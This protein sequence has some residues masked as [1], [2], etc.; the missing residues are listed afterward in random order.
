VPLDA[1]AILGSVAKTGRLVIVDLANKTCGAAAEIAAIAA[2]EVF[3]ALAAPIVRVTT[4]DV[5]IPFSP[6]LEMPLYPDK[7]KIVA[8]LR[9]VLELRAS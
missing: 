3:D 8:A 2:E 5:H 9:R 4:P 7:D 1:P 6:P